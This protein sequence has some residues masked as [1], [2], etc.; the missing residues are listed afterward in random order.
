MPRPGKVRI[1]GS[2]VLVHVVKITACGVRLPDFDQRMRNRTAIFAKHASAY[3]DPL[4]DGLAWVLTGQV[5]RFGI[6]DRRMEGRAGDFGKGRNEIHR[7]LRRCAFGRR[8]VRRMKMIGLRTR[9]RPAIAE[10]LRHERSS[11]KTPRA[12][13]IRD[14]RSAS[15]RR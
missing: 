12:R 4:A 15:S 3:D 1:E 11:N 8:G 14:G 13:E 9:I 5:K 7:G 6:D 2:V 10:E